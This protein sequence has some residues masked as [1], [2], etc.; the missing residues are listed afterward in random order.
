ML[1]KVT[2][3]VIGSKSTK[4]VESLTILSEDSLNMAFPYCPYQEDY[5]Y[6]YSKFESLQAPFPAQ[7]NQCFI[8][9]LKALWY[10]SLP[11]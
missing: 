10:L 8:S 11:N 1:A 7:K 5:S 4:D 2:S 9:P 3:S 6:N